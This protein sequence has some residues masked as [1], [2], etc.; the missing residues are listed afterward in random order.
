[1]APP[2][3]YLI[4]A[5][6]S[7]RLDAAE[8]VLLQLFGF[9]NEVR[10]YVFLKTSM[11]PDHQVLAQEAVTLNTQNHHQ[12]T[13]KVRVRPHEI[14]VI[15]V[16]VIVAVN[17]PR[18]L[19]LQ[20]YPGQLPRTVSHVILHVQSEEI[21]KHLSIPVSRTNG[22]LFIQTDKPLY[23]PHQSSENPHNALHQNS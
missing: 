16:V 15:T 6:L 22:F 9:T 17:V 14:S 7:L 21:N 23:T 11:A 13:A 20:L 19:S 4:T 12:A 18:P 8:T 3:R 1:M 2:L 5:P 10:V